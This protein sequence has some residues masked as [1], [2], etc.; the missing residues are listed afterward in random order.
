[1]NVLGTLLSRHKCIKSYQI[2]HYLNQDN[3]FASLKISFLFSC[4][5]IIMDG[6]TVGR[7]ILEVGNRLFEEVGSTLCVLD[8]SQ[9]ICTWLPMGATDYVIM[10]TYIYIII[11]YSESCCSTLWWFCRTSFFKFA[12][13]NILIPYFPTVWPLCFRDHFQDYLHGSRRSAESW[14]PPWHLIVVMMNIIWWT[15]H[16]EMIA[17]IVVV[18]QIA[19]LRLNSF[20]F[21]WGQFEIVP[22]F[23]TFVRLSSPWEA[24]PY[25]SLIHPYKPWGPLRSLPSWELPWKLGLGSSRM[26]IFLLL[27]LRRH[28]TIP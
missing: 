13:R 8:V 24:I 26:E 12:L 20:C 27:P 10:H 28:E 14:K 17:I 4:A 2:Q 23:Y 15:Y 16:D 25:L 19:H 22:I 9:M 7:W 5:E 11:I 6:E 21:F 3:I 1:M 18:K